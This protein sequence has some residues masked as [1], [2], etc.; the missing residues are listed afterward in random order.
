MADLFRA[1]WTDAIHDEWIRTLLGDRP[2]LKPEQLERTR[3]LMNAQSAI[4]LS[5][6]TRASSHRSR[7]P[8]QTTVTSW[9][10]PSEPERTRS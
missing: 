8:T 2:D 7:C 6:V 9:P 5:P 4:A 1:K 10:R 3:D